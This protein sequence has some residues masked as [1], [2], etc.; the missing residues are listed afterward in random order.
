[1]EYLLG[2]FGKTWFVNNITGR[3]GLTDSRVAQCQIPLFNPL[4]SH[5]IHLML[6]KFQPASSADTNED[7]VIK[8]LD[9]LTGF[10]EQF[11]LS[12]KCFK[13]C[14][15]SC[16]DVAAK[17]SLSSSPLW[18]SWWCKPCGAYHLLTLQFFRP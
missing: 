3:Q 5:L 17:K 1:M 14:L 16:L 13:I 4:S 6:F 15:F 7:C 12:R 2:N 9:I 10:R 8:S 18:H 11:L